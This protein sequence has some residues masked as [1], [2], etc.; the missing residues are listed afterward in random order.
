MAQLM[1]NLSNF[2]AGDLAPGTTWQ[3]QGRPP[4]GLDNLPHFVLLMIDGAV[5]AN[6]FKYYEDLFYNYDNKSAVEKN[7]P[8]KATFF[9]EHEYC[10]YYMVEQ[11]FVEGHEIALSSG[12][13]TLSF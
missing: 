11:L 5:N 2:H 8:L 7:A 13:V 12:E 6:N 10:D 3:P 9:I 4:K 1:R